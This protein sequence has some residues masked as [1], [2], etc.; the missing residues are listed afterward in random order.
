MPKT[1]YALLVGINDYQAPVPKLSG[2]VPDVKAVEA[3]LRGLPDTPVEFMI[4]T[5]KAAT[6]NKIVSGFRDHLSKAKTD[7]VAFFYFSGHGTQEDADEVFWRSEPS[8]CLQA[9]VCY[10]GIV[11]KNGQQAFNLLADKEL[12]YLLHELS[13]NSAH[14]LTVFDCCH[15]GDNTRS[16]QPKV[17]ARRYAPQNRLTFAVPQRNWNQF[18]FS[19]KLSREAFAKQSVADLMPEGRHIQIAACA[20]DESAFEQDG[21]GMFTRTLLDVLERS[22]SKVSYYNLESRVRSLLKNNFRQ[23]PRIYASAGHPDE[24]FHNFLDRK[25]EVGGSLYGNVLHRPGIGWYLELGY[26]AAIA[27]F[28]KTLPVLSQD[29]QQKFNARIGKTAGGRIELVFDGDAPDEQGL[30]KA[31]LAGLLSAQLAVYFEVKTPESVGLQ[32]A[33]QAWKE[34]G[35]G[36]VRATAEKDADYTLVISDKAYTLT[37]PEDRQRR[38]LT[39]VLTGFDPNQAGLALDWLQHISRWEFVKDLRNEYPTGTERLL[40]PNSIELEVFKV[41]AKEEQ[42][43]PLEG[44]EVSLAYEQQ[45]DGSLGG[46]IKIRLTNRFSRDLHVALLYLSMNFGSDGALLKPSVYKLKPGESIWTFEGKVIPLTYEAQVKEF[47]L[48]ESLTRLKLIVNTEFF[49]VTPLLLN[50]LPPPTVRSAGRLR[51]AGRKEPGDTQDWIT[52]LVTLR[53]PNPN[54]KDE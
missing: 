37:K 40:K 10:D 3:Y 1:I 47:N 34:A 42:L 8:H 36:L 32:F 15:S 25:G 43:L 41:V 4:L 27:P 26:S 2:C 17:A 6:K 21:S 53:M 48:R 13:K 9:L 30:Y 51:S 24:L 28:A 38:P 7:D 46:R 11:E 5:D 19:D 35:S 52:R 45:T 29:G 31:P 12:R 23:T 33:E 44:D 18:I 54:Y 50:D 20:P 39:P 22:E 49:D 16:Q 14:I